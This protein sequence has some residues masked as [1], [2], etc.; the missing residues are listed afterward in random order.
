MHSLKRNINI[1]AGL[2]I[3][4]TLLFHNS[5]A[6][7]FENKIAKGFTLSIQEQNNS[8]SE[9]CFQ[10]Q[11]TKKISAIKIPRTRRKYFRDERNI[12]I[13]DFNNTVPKFYFT[14]LSVTIDNADYF[15]Q[16]S[17]SSYFLRGPPLV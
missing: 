6:T 13:N 1:V 9:N 15:P 14:S 11:K 7:A 5:K 12:S 3:L 2:I 17:V 4:F 8:H 10:T 16:A